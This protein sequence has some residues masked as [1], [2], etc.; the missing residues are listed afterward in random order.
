MIFWN[1]SIVTAR[2]YVN[3]LQS[4]AEKRGEASLLCIDP[5]GTASQLGCSLHSGRQFKRD[6]SAPSSGRPVEPFSLIREERLSSPVVVDLSPPSLSGTLMQ[7]IRVISVLL[8]FDLL[9][10]L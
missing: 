9:Y 1:S 8:F 7:A 3:D 10:C 2:I 4:T 5:S 6:R